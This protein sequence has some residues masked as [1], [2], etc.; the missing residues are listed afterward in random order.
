MQKRGQV[1][2]ALPPNYFLAAHGLHPPAAG[3]IALPPFAV[4]QGPHAARASVGIRGTSASENPVVAPSRAL[5]MVGLAPI[6]GPA[7]SDHMQTSI[8]PYVWLQERTMHCVHDCV[9]SRAIPARRRRRPWG[10]DPLRRTC[11]DAQGLARPG[12]RL[13]CPVRVR[14]RAPPRPACDMLLSRDRDKALKSMRIVV[15]NLGL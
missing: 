7:S 12:W 15:P 1:S 2:S 3:S 6:R 11:L 8:E 10:N 9:L 13:P 5:C 14:C 4:L